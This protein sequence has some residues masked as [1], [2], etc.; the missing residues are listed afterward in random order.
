[1]CKSKKLICVKHK[2]VLHMNAGRHYSSNIKLPL[3]ARC[4]NSIRWCWWR[5]RWSEQQ[6]PLQ[7]N[8]FFINW[9][10]QNKKKKKKFDLFL[11]SCHLKNC[12]TFPP[13]HSVQVHL[14]GFSR[15]VF[16]GKHNVNRVLLFKKVAE[17][18]KECD[19]HVKKKKHKGGR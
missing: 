12:D 7:I 6:Q 9:Q 3:G 1:M 17:H 11:L 5:W 18:R 10:E 16:G 14:L 4:S 8:K 2:R 15:C 13:T 19:V